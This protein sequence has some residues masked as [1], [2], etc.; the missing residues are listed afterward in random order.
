M[1]LFNKSIPWSWNSKI[2]KQN[3]YIALSELFK[4]KI[5]HFILEFAINSICIGNDINIRYCKKY[6]F[7]RQNIKFFY[8]SALIIL[9]KNYYWHLLEYIILFNQI[10][11]SQN[12]KCRIMSILCRIIESFAINLNFYEY[13]YMSMSKLLTFDNGFINNILFLF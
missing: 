3:P 7:L 2:I 6:K 8:K 4:L 10:L 11:I 9:L 1:Y 12:Y 5:K 13:E